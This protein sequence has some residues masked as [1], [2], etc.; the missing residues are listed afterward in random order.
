MFKKS[1]KTGYIEIFQKKFY[2]HYLKSPR[3]CH[4]RVMEKSL[5]F[6]LE[7]LYEACEKQ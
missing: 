6:I 2:R 7:F 4:G 1:V 5:N 3:K